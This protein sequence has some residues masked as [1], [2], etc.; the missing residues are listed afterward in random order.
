MREVEVEVEEVVVVVAVDEGNFDKGKE[1]LE[2]ELYFVFEAN[3]TM[4]FLLGRK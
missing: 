3:D 2:R 4:C 1:G